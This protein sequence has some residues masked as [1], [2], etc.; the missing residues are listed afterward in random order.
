MKR[1][2]ITHRTAD[3]S[4]VPRRFT[5]IE[6]LVVIAIIAI[7]AAMLLPA[8][9]QARERAKFT[10]CSN[11]LKTSG[12]YVNFYAS[13]NR[14]RAPFAYRDG[15][16]ASGYL[17]GEVGSWFCLL[18]SYAGYGRHKNKYQLSQSYST[19]VPYTK[20]G[21]WSCPALPDANSGSRGTKIDFPISI[22]AKGKVPSPGPLGPVYQ[23]LYSK[24]RNPGNTAWI[25]DCRS[26]GGGNNAMYVNLNPGPNFDGVSW[27]HFGGSSAQ[28]Q[29]VDGHVK[30]YP[31]AK[32]SQMHR[33]PYAI[34]KY[35]M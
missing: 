30:A 27:G 33:G 19:L 29:H 8:L 4:H 28:V 10:T 12:T 34:F 21:V 20:P 31:P 5:L 18:A 3:G 1:T 22:G 25:L 17:P 23:L 26:T 6:L 11:N 16:S 7:L 9:Q 35:V 24:I 2:P 14:D 15:A 13:D 32:L